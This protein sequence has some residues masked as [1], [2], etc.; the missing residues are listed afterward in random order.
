VALCRTRYVH[1]Q[2][3]AGNSVACAE[4][5][6]ARDNHPDYLVGYDNFRRGPSVY[7]GIVQFS[8]MDNKL[9][10]LY[11]GVCRTKGLHGADSRANPHEI[12]SVHCEGYF[13]IIHTS[14]ILF[15]ESN[16]IANM[17]F[18]ISV[19][20]VVYTDKQNVL[21]LDKLQAVF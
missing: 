20:T 15:K 8:C 11:L 7:Y 1:K 14:L 17:A 10:F 16:G 9:G 3:P 13:C 21:L 12:S 4:H 18:A 5:D 6:D 19:Y 2:R